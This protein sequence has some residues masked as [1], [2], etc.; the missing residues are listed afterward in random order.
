MRFTLA[1][2]LSVVFSL[3]AAPVLAAD[4]W[5]R[6]AD[7]AHGYALDLPTGSFGEP[8]R[9]VDTGLV[10][11]SELEGAGLIEVY[12]G[13]NPKGLP[14]SDFADELSRAERIADVTYRADGKTWFVLSGHYR[15]EADERQDLIYYAKFVFTPGHARF[16]AFEISY[17]VTEKLRMDPVVAHLE[18]SLRIR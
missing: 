4:G 3:V 15:R 11:L 8:E 9:D 14:V 2:Q 10:H 18:R 6:F 13:V 5:H 12:S 16:A 17:P 1:A 7:P